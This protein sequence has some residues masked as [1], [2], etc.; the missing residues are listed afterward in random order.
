[1]FS[2]IIGGSGSGKSAFA[3]SLVSRLSGRRIYLATM[4]S[5][6][7]EAFSRIARHRAQRRELAFETIECPVNLAALDLPDNANVLLE[8]LG[9]LLANELFSPQ[10]G[11][12][13]QA[14][15]GIEAL[16]LRCAHL[17]VVTN[18]VFS[19]GD[20]YEGETLRYLRELALL[21]RSLAAEAEL[22]AELVC[23][24]PNLLKGE[25]PA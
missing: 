2:L 14:L 1:M 15:R 6:G 24:L 18:E 12:A 21:N 25:L 22:V 19:G 8:D 7:E 23:G 3:E 16:R 5:D 11:G 9:N 4:R 10:G 20:R 13:E 17:A